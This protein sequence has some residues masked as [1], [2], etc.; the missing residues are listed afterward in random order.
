MF[1]LPWPAPLVEGTL[2]RRYHR[3]LTDVR[4]LSGELVRAHCVNTGV[5]EGLVRP[6]ARVWLCPALTPGRKLP[7][8]WVSME[9][10]DGIRVGVDTSLPNRL[11]GAMLEARRLPGFE[12]HRGFAAEVSYGEGS[13]VDFSVKMARGPRLLEVKN[14]H[15]VYPDGGAYFPDS[16]SARG[17]RHLRELA[18][19]ARAGGKASVVFIVQRHDARF[20]RPSDV[21]DPTFAAEARLAADAGVTFS[22]LRLR[23]DPEGVSVLDPVPVDLAPFPTDEPHRWRLEGRRWSGWERPPREG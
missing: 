9:L 12:R 17:A 1:S 14:C 18:A 10:P 23:P 11:V 15:L 19:V 3:F 4:L 5:M 20:V 22:A 7:F 6:G 16:V 2:L 21:H 13:R 8:T